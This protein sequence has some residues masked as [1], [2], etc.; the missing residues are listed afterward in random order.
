MKLR[1]WHRQFTSRG[2]VLQWLAPFFRP[3]FPLPDTRPYALRSP[4]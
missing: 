4:T 2:G 1:A 3:N